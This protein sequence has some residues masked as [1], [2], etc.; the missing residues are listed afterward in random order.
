MK[1]PILGAILLV[2]LAGPALAQRRADAENLKLLGHSDLEGRRAAQ[3]V[4]VEQDGRW[5]A[6]IAHVGGS[7]DNP[8]PINPLTRR[9]EDNGTSIVDVTNPRHPK[10]LHHIPGA[11]GAHD[12]GGAPS[13][14]VCSGKTLPKANPA[15][16]YLLRSF[17]DSAH[18]LWDVTDPVKPEL[19]FRI[20]G[21]EGTR[22]NW[23]E[24]DTGI[25]YL[26]SSAPGWRVKHMTEIYDLSNPEHPVYVRH[27]GLVGQQP[28][29]TGPTPPELNTA[30][31]TGPKGNRVYFGY[32]RDKD[33]ILQ[34]VDRDKLLSGPKEPMPKN[35]LYPQ[36]GRLDL[37][38]LSGANSLFP[39]IGMKIAEFADDAASTRDFVVVTG[40]EVAPECQEPRQMAW[41][42]DVTSEARPMV[43][44]SYTPAQESGDFCTLGGRFGLHSSNTSMM[45][46]YYGKLLFFAAFNAGVRVV[47]V[48]DPYHPIEV[49]HYIPALTSHGEASC[50]D[51]AG[52]KHCVKVIQTS[53]VEV[54]DRGYVYITD[55]AGNGLD[56]LELT[57]EPHRIAEFS[58]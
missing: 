51:V 54:D 50:A 57:G 46:T 18:E 31:S 41:F 10:Y 55:R 12:E 36:V 56:I 27:F 15:K 35:L 3:P 11:A 58:H 4:I 34:I 45:A 44:S 38:A 53:N 28:G 2:A 14:Q 24:C 32:G 30:V 6:Y 16:T 25:A 37:S 19:L 26:V 29:A 43:V 9:H 33:G 13:V 1:V 22:D 47:D 8:R 5:I 49:G 20:E 40:E 21:V 17:G 23:W 7:A 42:V 39:L 52:N 48:R